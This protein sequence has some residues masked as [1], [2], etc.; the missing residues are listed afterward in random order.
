MSVWYAHIVAGQRK[1]IPPSKIFQFRKVLRG[2][3]T[4]PVWYEELCL[5][6]PKASQLVWAPDEKLYALCVEAEAAQASPQHSWHGLPLC[7][8][9]LIYKPFEAS[10]WTAMRQLTTKA[11]DMSTLISNLSEI[12]P[13]G[14]VHVRGISILFR[15]GFLDICALL[16]NRRCAD[17]N[18]KCSF[19]A[20]HPC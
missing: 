8:S 20:Q 13:L 6:W 11:V 4:P 17:G 16:D 5:K 19:P 2:T 9:H 18:P 14:P 7:Q 1:D 12:E 10:L 3:N 15:I